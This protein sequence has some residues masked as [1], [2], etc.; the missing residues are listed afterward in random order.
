MSSSKYQGPERRKNGN[1]GRRAEDNGNWLYRKR[2]HLVSI[3]IAAFSAVIL[4]MYNANRERAI[5]GQTAANAICALKNDLQRRVD[6]T[7]EFI[8]NL[9][10]GKRDPIPGITVADLERSASS[11]N[12]T[13]AALAVINCPREPK[14]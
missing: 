3:W 11:M 2:W 13:I 9:K 1:Y 4:L 14:P 6:S 12:Q 8:A 5:E 10:S 7:E